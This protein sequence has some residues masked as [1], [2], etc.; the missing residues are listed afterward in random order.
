MTLRTKCTLFLSLSVCV[1]VYFQFVMMMYNVVS[2]KDLKLRQGLKLI[3]LKD[4]V[5]W[6]SWYV[7]YLEVIVILPNYTM[8]YH[9]I[10]AASPL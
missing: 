7:I 1:F 3:G 10:I 9:V 6:I 4:S 2:E 8:H 5:Y